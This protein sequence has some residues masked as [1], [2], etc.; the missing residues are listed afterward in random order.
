MG[1]YV[2]KT[3]QSLHRYKFLESFC[4]SFNEKHFSSRV[5]AAEFLNEIAVPYVKK[6]ESRCLSSN[7]KALIIFDGFKS[8][9]IDEVL[10]LLAKSHIPVTTVPADKT[11]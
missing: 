8:Q 11:N 9:M 10:G 5:E 7:Q 4:L 6:R 1:I 3:M 2:A